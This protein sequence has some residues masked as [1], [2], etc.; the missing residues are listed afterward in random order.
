MPVAIGVGLKKDG[1][2]RVFGGVRSDGERG[3][4]VRE[5]KDGFGE[6]EALEGFKGRL[7]RG[8]PVPGE[9][10]LG[11]VK[12][13]MSDVGIVG[14]EPTVEVGEPKERVN[15]SH[16]G[17]RRPIC[18]AVKFDGVHGQLAG[19]YDHPEVFHLIGGE[20]ALL[21]FQVKVKFCHA[22]ENALRALFVE[23]GVG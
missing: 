10:F 8:R 21:E 23:G 7:T 13:G 2:R 6:E 20:L 19:F 22:L 3:G 16:F 9:V 15:V 14:N 4:E 18:N 17:W 5:V 12:E 11:K 1:T